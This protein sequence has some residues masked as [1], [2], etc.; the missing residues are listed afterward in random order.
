MSVSSAASSGLPGLDSIINSLRMGDNVVWQVDNIDD[1]RYFVDAFVKQGHKD[2]RKIVYFR[3]AQHP[4]VLHGDT[5]VKVYEL[6]A[7]SGFEQFSAQIHNIATEEG[8]DVYYV[9]DCLSDLLNAWATDLMI[10]NFFVVTCPYLFEL[11]TIAYFAILKNNHS[12]KTIA[13]IRDTTQLLL[14]TYRS[15]SKLYVHP[16][17]VWK[18]YAPTM[19]LPHLQDGDKFIPI[20]NSIEIAKLFTKISNQETLNAKRQLDYW[21]R[22]FLDVEELIEDKKTENAE[23]RNRIIDKICRVMIGKDERVISL[24]NRHFSLEDLLAIKSRVIGTG[25][26][27]GKAVGMLLARN[28]LTCDKTSDWTQTLEPHDSFY[29]GSDVF[30]SYIVQNGWWKTLMEQKTDE[31]YFEKGKVLKENLKQ[32]VFP[33]EIRDQF[34]QMLEYYGQSPI[35]VRSSSL[36]EDGFG[37][38]FAGKYESIFCVNQGSTEERYDQFEN[39]VRA[40]YASGMNEDALAYR[41]Q[42]GLAHHDE[43]MALLV[44]RVSGS[45]HK[46]YYFPEI[47][48]VGFS[49][50]TFVWKENMDPAAGMLRIVYGL[51]TRSVERVEDDY[52]RIVALD[53]PQLKPHA[54][55]EDTR[56]FSQRKVD[57]LDVAENRL[58]TLAFSKL[59]KEE[60]SLKL[61]LI[62]I[63][64]FETTQKLREA[65]KNEEAWIITFD[66]LMKKT[67]FIPTMRSMLKQLEKSYD[68]P[69]DIEYTVNFS[70]E[71]TL[72]VNLLQCR[73]LQTKGNHKKVE[74]P[75]KVPV[76]DVLFRSSGNF[77]GGSISQRIKR[78]IFIKPQEYGALKENLKYDIARLIGKLN[79][80]VPNKDELPMMLMGPGRWG[81]TT[82]SLGVPVS[83]SEISNVSVLSEVA[84]PIAGLMPELS[85][86][87]HF[88]QDLVET[89]I[90]YIALFPDKDSVLFNETL[91]NEM[92]NQLEELQPDMA[93]YANVVKVVD[94]NDRNLLLLADLISQKVLCY[95]S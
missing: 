45:Y 79:R 84:Y 61:D 75:E 19:F 88:F 87:T 7:D 66:E 38:A 21:D 51:G 5:N 92:P 72:Q 85:F 40:I 2:N 81:T 50:N 30:Y 90:F 67:Q 56:F 59:I 15:R 31:G 18:R 33:D 89:G 26:I 95:L 42:R 24:V 37:N 53:L 29:I 49:Y 6:E 62:A 74:I 35:I 36:L 86:G 76:R 41:L 32:G 13:R 17:K 14:D 11:N 47:A 94:L 54:G 1:Y 8:R 57:L 83:F 68:Y 20:T 73:P 48:G 3:F 43:Q 46:K 28:I 69:V 39:A 10:G 60:P 78:I 52:P 16:I 22:L 91:L 64:D 82:P 25:F 58:V 44:Q 55:M 27:G 71:G 12:F 65:G 93:H 63:R 77:M 80:M 23:V 70:N 4:P 9:F 34:L